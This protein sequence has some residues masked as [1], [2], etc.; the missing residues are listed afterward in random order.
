MIAQVL[1]NKQLLIFSLSFVNEFIL[2]F[3]LV[4]AKMQV[5]VLLFNSL[6]EKGSEEMT[7]Q[8]R[9]RL[10]SLLTCLVFALTSLMSIAFIIEHSEHEC[11]EHECQVCF[12]IHSAQ[13]ILR[14][15]LGMTGAALLFLFILILLG[16]T[17][18]LYDFFIGYTSPIVLKV[19]M[20]N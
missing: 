11:S 14:H 12:H 13:K 2:K 9:R 3:F 17:R 10:I 20:N 19:R 8:S 4:Y 6:A 16:S 7:K 1:L 15:V 5:G 18:R